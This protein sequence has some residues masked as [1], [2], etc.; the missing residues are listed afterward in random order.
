MKLRTEKRQS[1]VAPGHGDVFPKLDRVISARVYEQ[2]R[3]QTKAKKRNRG[4]ARF[5]A[6]EHQ[7][8][9]AEFGQNNRRQQPPI[10]PDV[11]G[12]LANALDDGSAE[13]VTY[14]RL[15]CVRNI[16]SPA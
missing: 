12:N 3:Q 6:E 16:V 13:S 11:T 14:P 9:A 5:Q 2:R 4:P 1:K 7:R 8:A 15:Y 10:H